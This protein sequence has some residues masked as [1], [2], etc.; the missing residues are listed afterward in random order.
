MGYKPDAGRDNYSERRDRGTNEVGP[1]EAR[2]SLGRFENFFVSF[3]GGHFIGLDLFVQ[4]RH[5]SRCKFHEF[6]ERLDGSCFRS[7]KICAGR[8]YRGLLMKFFG[9]RFK[10]SECSLLCR[11]KFFIA[12]NV[13]QPF[14]V[15]IS[16]K[17]SVGKA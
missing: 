4:L 10:L 13:H 15:I 2:G 5:G 14:K 17:E 11:I 9:H 8:S 1:V 16:Q 3:L 7:E 12:Q 6:S